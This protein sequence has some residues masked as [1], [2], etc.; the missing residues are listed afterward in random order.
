M[1]LLFLDID[2]VL[3]R[4]NF[5]QVAGSNTLL[6]ECVEQLNRIIHETGA[7]IVLSS[8]WRYM[9]LGKDVTLKGFEYLLRTHGVTSKIEIVGITPAD[10]ICCH[11]G[12]REM[13]AAFCVKCI[14]RSDRGDQ[15][16]DYL[17]T[18]EDVDTYV[19][20]DDLNLGIRG[21]H[22]FVQ[23]ESHEGITKADADKIIKLLM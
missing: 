21:K 11:C 16:A 13:M 17:K 19:V 14:R 8:A 12:S 22:P 18:A 7:K 5:N 15:I 2:G 6:P 3:N 20:V 1:K 23:T 4:H 9:V 10:E